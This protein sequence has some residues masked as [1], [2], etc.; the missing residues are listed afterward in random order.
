MGGLVLPPCRG[1]LL[2]VLDQMLP[3]LPDDPRSICFSSPLMFLSK[4]VTHAALVLQQLLASNRP[5][6]DVRS[7]I[8]LQ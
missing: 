4:A 2:A 7:V 1:S 5:V 8:L 6:L 3:S